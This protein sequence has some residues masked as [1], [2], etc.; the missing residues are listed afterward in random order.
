MD[1][2]QRPDRDAEGLGAEE[3]D[4]LAQSVLEGPGAE[5]PRDE[6]AGKAPEGGAGGGRLDDLDEVAEAARAAEERGE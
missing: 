4:A 1:E 5:A 2:R 3:Q 6:L